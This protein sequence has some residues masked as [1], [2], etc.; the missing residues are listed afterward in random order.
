MSDPSGLPALK[1][2]NIG[3]PLGLPFP[4]LHQR[5]IPVEAEIDLPSQI[6][7]CNVIPWMTSATIT[8]ATPKIFRTDEPFIGHAQCIHHHVTVHISQLVADLHDRVGH[9]NL[10]GDEGVV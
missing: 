1:H 2:Q 3:K 10:S 9:G 6:A 7:Q 8:H 5:I 4:L